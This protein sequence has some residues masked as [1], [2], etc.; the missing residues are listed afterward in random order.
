METL[1]LNESGTLSFNSSSQD[2]LQKKKHP[3][4]IQPSCHFQEN[5]PNSFESYL[6]FIEDTVKH[7]L[8][9]EF[10]TALSQK[11]A[12]LKEHIQALNDLLPLISWITPH[13][14]PSTLSMTCLCPADFTS[15]VGRYLGDALSRWL[16]P[17]K[18]LN[19]TS[20]QSLNFKFTAFPETAFFIQQILMDIDDEKD[21]LI[22]RNNAEELGK[23][24]RLNILAVKHA[25]QVVTI[26][27]LSSEQ[28]K[29]IIQ[30][31]IASVLERPSKNLVQS[32]F[33]QM[34]HFL[35]HLSDEDKLSHIKDQFAPFMEQRPKVFD[36]DIF[37]EVK[38]LILLFQAPFTS[39]RDFRHVGRII[40]YQ[41]LF[42]KSLQHETLSSPQERHLSIKLMK[43]ALRDPT[44]PK[45]KRTVL[46]IL[47]G[48]NVLRENELFE[49][50]HITEAIQRCLPGIKKIENS[51]VIDR[52]SHDP[53]RTFYIEVEK[54]KG[55]HFSL[56]ELKELQRQLPLELKES[57]ENVIH[58][59]FMPRNE[60]EIMRNILILS[61]QLKYIHDIPQVIIT[62]DQQTEE[63]L[64]FTVILLRLIKPS[65]VSIREHF[66]RSKTHLKFQSHEVKYVGT[67]RKRYL[68]EANVFSLKTEKKPF[69]RKDY[70]LDLFKARQAISA[71]LHRILG[72]I[73]D[74]NGGILSKQQEVFHQ[75]R[76]SITDIHSYQ[77]FLLENFF[78]SLSPPLR[79]TLLPP[80][81]LKKLFNIQQEALQVDYRKDFFSLKAYMDGQFLLLLA[82]SPHAGIKEELNVTITSLDVPSS[83]LSTT[84]VHA[85]GIYCI[86]YIYQDIDHHRRTIFYESIYDALHRWQHRFKK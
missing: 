46:S 25:R 76:E 43:T 36:R 82:A 30:E 15:G 86:G 83:A 29:I 73:R 70:T 22:I 74:F 19:I 37:H 59:V 12:D 79:Q 72:G 42:R 78:Y 26:K 67:V 5:H 68:K 18:F 34:H 48:I 17:G 60:E 58:P 80:V 3:F 54:E 33:D 41:Y 52:R 71:E 62:F 61:Q 16:I 57:I 28:K 4:I 6:H 13:Q 10:L 40:S 39:L 24:I 23:E 64:S 49:E 8:P 77:D 2:S 55:E 20:C 66:H 9:S 1:L 56:W 14:A 31:N 50:R 81:I 45:G 21:L 65:T 75:L 27:K 84:E 7:I 38:H 47:G 51:F 11:S 63:E 32:A 44:S 53:I 85:Y 35:V 69:L